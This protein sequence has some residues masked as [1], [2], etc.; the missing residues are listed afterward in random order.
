MSTD[1][2][3]YSSLK[4]YADENALDQP[5]KPDPKL[6]RMLTDK[7]RDERPDLVVDII[8]GNPLPE[9][10]RKR[11]NP[12]AS[13]KDLTAKEKEDK[14]KEYWKRHRSALFKRTMNQAKKYRSKFK[15]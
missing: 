8:L 2:L 15:R 10:I 9:N 14:D 1:K 7:E 6:M 5:L 4:E 13:R 11:I 12:P 3:P